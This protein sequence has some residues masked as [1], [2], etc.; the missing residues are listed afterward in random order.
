MSQGRKIS[1]AH[2]QPS[3]NNSTQPMI[4]STNWTLSTY[5]TKYWSPAGGDTATLGSDGTIAQHA[6]ILIAV[7]GTLNNLRLDCDITVATAAVIVNVYKNNVLSAL[8]AQIIVG[9]TTG[10]SA[11]LQLAVAAGDYI[12]FEM[13]P[14]TA[15]GVTLGAASMQFVPT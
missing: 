5:K 11:A 7:P 15:T 12:S 1:I 13:P 9:A 3:Q 2:D 6:G 8:T 4:F 10:N 14:T